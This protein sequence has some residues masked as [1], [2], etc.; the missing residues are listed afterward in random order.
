MLSSPRSLGTKSA[1][2]RSLTAASRYDQ[3]YVVC[4][5]SMPELLHSFND[6]L[7]QSGCK[8]V[9]FFVQ[10]REQT[11]FPKLPFFR[12]CG[13]SDSVR[14]HHKGVFRKKLHLGNV[15]LPFLKQSQDSAGDR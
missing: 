1:T 12:I 9:A 3:R 11:A 7:E 5:L 10:N 14:I 6:R 2:N 13:F 4:L 15:A 8:E